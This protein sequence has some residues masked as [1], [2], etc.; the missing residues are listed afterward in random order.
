MIYFLPALYK[1]GETSLPLLNHYEA[2]AYCNKSGQ[3]LSL[4]VDDVSNQTF[5]V[6]INVVKQ[7]H[8]EWMADMEERPGR[9]Y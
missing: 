1:P 5:P 2:R 3:E 8:D 4:N 9:L 7:I 6:W